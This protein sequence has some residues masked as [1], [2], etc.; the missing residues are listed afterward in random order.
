MCGLSCSVMEMKMQII[1]AILALLIWVEAAS[2]QA[3][4][5]QKTYSLSVSRHVAVPE[6]TVEQVNK[7]LADASKM[8]QTDPGH[9]CNVKFTLN[10]SIGT[11]GAPD[12]P[13][14]DI[15]A[16][17]DADHITAVHSL[18][19]GVDSDFHIKVVEEIKPHCVPNHGLESGFQGCSFPHDFRSIIVVHPDRH[20][21]QVRHADGSFEDKLVTVLFPNKT[22]P[23]HLLWAHEFGHLT[24]LGH[25]ETTPPMRNNED[26]CAVTT[27]PNAPPLSDRCALMRDREVFRFVLENLDRVQVS[28]RECGCFLSGP[29]PSGACP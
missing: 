16:K 11:F 2:A 17:I 20:R 6:L 29:K 25:R 7:V 5:E 4:S 15:P 27:D 19:S 21:M 1:V 22:Y 28:E 26:H 23:E 13:T 18:D 3:A 24:G 12:T 9:A 10:G 8:L 14:A